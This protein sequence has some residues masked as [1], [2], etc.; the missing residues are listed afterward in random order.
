MAQM[1][2]V[3]KRACAA[4]EVAAS[5]NPKTVINPIAVTLRVTFEKFDFKAAS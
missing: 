4:K 2:A 1:P 3:S 5:K